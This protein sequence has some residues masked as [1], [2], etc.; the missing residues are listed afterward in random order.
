M[1]DISRRTGVSDLTDVELELLDVLAI[2][3]GPRAS[4]RT[5]VFEWQYNRPSHG[6]DDA[7]LQAT[8]DRFE[9]EGWT[10]GDDYASHWSESDRSIRLTPRGGQLWESERLPDWTRH[11]IAFGFGPPRPDSTRHRERVGGG[12]LVIVRA[13]FDARCRC[14]FFDFAAGP[15]R[16]C[17]AQR[18][19]IYWRP[20]QPLY[21]LSAWVESWGWDADRELLESMR[22][23]WQF[24]VEISKLWGLPPA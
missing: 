4:F 24:P 23:W 18:Q 5:G 7:A 12:S 16:M 19:W 2:M 1:A 11:V 17:V 9:K 10:T 3:S 6:L 8:L 20:P 21:L 22:C 13:F 15:I 14:G